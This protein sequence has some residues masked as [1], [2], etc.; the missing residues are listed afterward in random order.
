MNDDGK[1]LSDAGRDGCAPEAFC[2]DQG[3]R[4][5]KAFSKEIKLMVA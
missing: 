1:M 4:C 5:Q 3:V 2:G